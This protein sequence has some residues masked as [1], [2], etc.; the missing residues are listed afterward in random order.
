MKMTN[1]LIVCACAGMAAPAFAQPFRM[2][3][4]E[5]ED[6]VEGIMVACASTGAP[7]TTS[8]NQWWRDFDLGF[9]GLGDI[10]V[11]QVE[12][13]IQRFSAPSFAGETEV[14]I[15]LY[16]APAGSTPALGLELKGTATAKYLD[17]SFTGT[18]DDIFT[19]DFDG[20]VCIDAGASLI[21]EI[22]PQDFGGGGALTGDVAFL[23]GNGFGETAPSYL[24]STGCGLPA[25]ATFA[26]IGFSGI[27]TIMNIVGEEGH[28]CTGGCYAD[29][30]GSGSLDFFDFLCFQNAFA[31]GDDYADCDDSGSLDFFDFLCF[32]NEFAAGCP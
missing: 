9:F 18:P 10:T 4:N 26:S 15:N 16:Q 30:D 13:G 29:C 12:F 22:A 24:S 14:T 19:M 20:G 6:L 1:A 17:W 32:Q 28:S 23:G 11:T 27:S 8:D 2:S 7:Q 3:H 5:I 25:P 31:A 21:V